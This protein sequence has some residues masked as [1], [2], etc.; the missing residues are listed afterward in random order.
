M[1]RS[2]SKTTHYYWL[3]EQI[4]QIY[5]LVLDTQI[6]M[7]KVTH[8]TNDCKEVILYQCKYCD[9]WSYNKDANKFKVCSKKPFLM[10]LFNKHCVWKN[11]NTLQA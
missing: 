4:K 10:K 7:K 5:V 9:F 11:T 3:T 2:S 6:P 8:T 1:H